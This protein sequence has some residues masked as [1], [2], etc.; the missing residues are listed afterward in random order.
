MNAA[1]T[2]TLYEQMLLR[3]VRMVEAA[4]DDADADP[5]LV[6]ED[7]QIACQDALAHTH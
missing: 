4:N 7:I 2:I 3:I 1:D 6:L 5:W